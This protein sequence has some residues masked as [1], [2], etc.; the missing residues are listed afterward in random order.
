M[1]AKYQSQKSEKVKGKSKDP[2]YNTTWHTQAIIDDMFAEYGDEVMNEIGL[3]N[4]EHGRKRILES[5]QAFNKLKNT[6]TASNEESKA[7]ADA[8]AKAKTKEEEE[9]DT[10][11]VDNLEGYQLED[12]D[13]DS[14]N[15]E[16]QQW[17]EDEAEKSGEKEA[18]E[19]ESLME[20]HKAV[21]V[22]KEKARNSKNK[23]AKA[24]A[25]AEEKALEAETE[26]FINKNPSA[27]TKIIDELTK[28]SKA[29]AS[30]SKEES[31]S[32]AA[33]EWNQ[34]KGKGAPSFSKLSDSL[35]YEWML[36][37]TEFAAGNTTESTLEAD[38]SALEALHKET[39]SE[40]TKDGKDNSKSEDKS[41]KGSKGTRDVSKKSK[42]HG[43]GTKSDTGK[44]SKKPRNKGAE[45][46][47]LGKASL[48]S[49]SRDDL[50]A[51]AKFLGLE[52]GKSFGKSKIV[53]LI[54]NKNLN[55]VQAQDFAMRR[56]NIL[57]DANWMFTYPDLQSFIEKGDFKSFNAKLDL[58]SA[59]KD[60][61]AAE[62]ST[63]AAT[64][65]N[66]RE[67]SKIVD[68][69]ISR[70]EKASTKRELAMAISTVTD[71][72]VAQLETSTVPVLEARRDALVT[73]LKEKKKSNR[74]SRNKQLE[75]SSTKA[76][77]AL[78]LSK[79]HY[80]LFE[81]ELVKKSK[82]EL[83]KIKEIV[84]Q[85]IANQ[86]KGTKLSQ[87]HRIEVSTSK[88]E[89]AGIVMEMFPGYSNYAAQKVTKEEAIREIRKR[90][91][92]KN[93]TGKNRVT[94]LKFSVATKEVT[95]PSSK[96]KFTEMFYNL[97]GREKTKGI[98]HR[99]HFVSN[100][101]E[102]RATVL[103]LIAKAD[104]PV[105]YASMKQS[106]DNDVIS[107]KAV[108]FVTPRIDGEEHMVFVLGN[109]QSGS[110]EAVFM[111][112]VGSH[113]GLDNIL[114]ESEIKSL[115]NNIKSW[116][117]DENLNKKGLRYRIARAAGRRVAQAKAA[118][119]VQSARVENS[120]WIAYFIEEA[121]KAGVTPSAK[122]KLGKILQNIF[123][124]FNQAYSRFINY[125]L[126]TSNLL[127]TQN[128]VD[129]A[130]GAAKMELGGDAYR[131]STASEVEG[132]TPV[133]FSIDATQNN[134]E[135]RTTRNWVKDH[136]GE[137][138]A[139]VWDDLVEVFR[140]GADGTKFLHQFIRGVEKI[141]PSARE[142]HNAILRAERTRNEIK[143]LVE[144][145]NVRAR[146][147]SK[148]HLRAVNIF[149]GDS[150]FEQKWGYNPYETTDPKY[151]T[152]VVDDAMAKR[153]DKLN[154]EQQRVVKDVFSHGERMLA[155]KKLVAEKFGVDSSLFG[156]S[157]LDGPYAPL[158]RFGGFVSEFKSQKLI[159]AERTLEHS[160]SDNNKKV[161]EV[162]KTDPD[163]YVISFHPSMGTAKQHVDKYRGGYAYAE[164]SPKTKVITE[165]R[166]PDHKVI[167]KILGTMGASNLDKSS[168]EYKAMYDM[169]KEM[170][171]DTLDETNARHSQAKR[172]GRAGYEENMMRSFLSNATSEANLI[173]S[174]EH[175]ME[176]NTTLA[177]AKNDSDKDKGHLGRVYN[178]MVSHY[179]E[180]LNDKQT[181]IQ[182]RVAAVN[183]V[184][185][186]TS[187][188]GYHLTN[189]T[190]PIMVT[191]PK[192]VGDFGA[193]HYG[194]VIKLYWAGM[195]LAFNMVEFEYK[196]LKLQ[197]KIDISKAPK[198][199]Q[200]MLADLQL[201]QLLDVGIEQ[202][203]ADSISSDTG[204]EVI[205][206]ASEAA[207]TFTHR[208][209]QVARMVEAYNRISTATAAFEMAESNK[210]ATKRM[211]MTSEEYAINMV[212]DTQGNFS[213]MDSPLVLKKIPKITGQYRKYQIMMAWV[214]ADATKKAFVGTSAEEKAAGKRTIAFAMW[215][216]SLFSGAVGVPFLGWVAPLFLGMGN[217]GD[218]PE[219]LERWIRRNMGDNKFT[220][221]ITRG[222]P[223]VV[224][225]DM[226]TKL[227][228]QKIF[229][230]LPFSTFDGNQESMK[231]I[232]FEALLGPTASTASNFMRSFEYAKEGNLQRATEYALPKGVRTAMESYRLS[233][234]GYS[235][236]NGDVIPADFSGWSLALNAL[237]VPS[238]EINKV[239]WT[240]GQQYELGK[241][242]S[243]EQSAIR[244]DYVNASKNKDSSGRRDA[245][246]R[247]KA[248]QK[249]KA[250]LKPFFN[251]ERSA[252]KRTPL[253]NLFKAPSKQRKR[254][255]KYAKQAGY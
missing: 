78:A 190:Q 94:S 192:I 235:L 24:K 243:D 121:T 244:K 9:S 143:Q 44:S 245:I 186:L 200:P 111:H 69:Q 17:V 187:S 203:L 48:N 40:E 240:R 225:L 199:Y 49:M 37:M 160:P 165:G 101:N 79:I 31:F 144:D 84:L 83:L 87:K 142:W 45:Q 119:A 12:S 28:A 30:F 118:G 175:G 146:K 205:N 85:D 224:G 70:L 206:K 153:F 73:E 106:L 246:E 19:V 124:K 135:I 195:K 114:S 110:E 207:G 211:G 219:D 236:R 252:M 166:T 209:Y 242:A 108:A 64:K 34:R 80:N 105:A 253:S 96:E 97:L 234:D 68:P 145:I 230:P 65:S 223:A 169:V 226:S 171:F 76:D 57:Y 249:S 21:A 74:K 198:K 237:G 137:K 218:E 239:K 189:A 212:E 213:A 155:R 126:G 71:Q 197:T 232:V 228:Q 174:M 26:A 91:N 99:I 109:T 133:K 158:K 104:D 60:A 152:V 241:W 14:L 164:A 46:Y 202:D 8:K 131:L 180:H 163:H 181:P 185:M 36:S 98:F 220:D 138:T 125:N 59:K 90:L 162:F 170:Y 7:D 39:K 217:E 89:L 75:D 156:V 215:H 13:T 66:K 210:E 184:Y 29:V 193:T 47:H 51:Y 159:D 81:S 53:S 72:D 93:R 134:Q 254:E 140:S 62:A 154:P 214:Y 182:D 128:I 120:E 82:V 107:S 191:I 127:S 52:V 238:T 55:F 103:E 132:N 123:R 196:G 113:I 77:I 161:V 208:L 222:L 172:M 229:H 147:L 141:M 122:T 5:I 15:E 4:D 86:V 43:T 25:K 129:M 231:E 50:F 35:K 251:N 10:L 67:V 168:K 116:A 115:A 227:S 33:K 157:G 16:T 247:W 18:A 173:A 250:K 149:L 139:Q 88:K 150:T 6:E 216:A 148:E 201:R 56:V 32:I 27:K 38:Q 63:K 2:D 151:K 95:N 42:K 255:D 183:T 3:V 102:A 20:R 179:V 58:I 178:M 112:E 54:Q 167:A 92:T 136:F 194:K 177:K 100:T 1:W 176:I 204:Y 130:Y 248:L 117:S 22:R 11:V 221:L 61:S 41:E 23:K 188:F 233:T